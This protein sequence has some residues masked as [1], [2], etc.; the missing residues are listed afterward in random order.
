MSQK[1]F[2]IGEQPFAAHLQS[3]DSNQLLITPVQAGVALGYAPQTTWN[4]LSSGK[5]PVPTV[6]CG[7]RKM[8]R[9]ADLVKYVDDL[10]PNASAINKQQCRP[11][12]PTKEEEVLRRDAGKK[13]GEA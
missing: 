4:L 10:E 2:Q 13:G 1:K 3:F 9:I 12:R 5:F 11:G 8:V 6:R 7:K